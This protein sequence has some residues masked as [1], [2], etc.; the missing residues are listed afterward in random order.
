MS[1]GVTPI[2]DLGWEEIPKKFIAIVLKSPI[3]IITLVH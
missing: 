2:P 1:N 3:A